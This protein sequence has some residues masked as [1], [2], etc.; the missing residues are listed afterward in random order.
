VYSYNDLMGGPEPFDPYAA[1]A[2]PATAGSGAEGTYTADIRM[3]GSSTRQHMGQLSGQRIW[4][5]IHNCLVDICPHERG[6]IGCYEDMPSAGL[7]DP[8][9]PRTFKYRN[10][11]QIENVPYQDAKGGYSTDAS[12]NIEARVIYR[13]KKYPGLGEAI[14][15]REFYGKTC[16]LLTL[17][18]MRWLQAYTRRSL[19]TRPTATS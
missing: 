9:N 8:T 16:H 7:K 17:Y 13:S 12:I 4:Q 15:S 19:R 11:C 5:A 6:G 1:L 10:M 18:S 2:I 3:S 14:V